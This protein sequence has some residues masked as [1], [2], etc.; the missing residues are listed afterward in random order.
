V[1][2]FAALFSSSRYAMEQFSMTST[3]IDG[4]GVQS[5]NNATILR[6]NR[7]REAAIGAG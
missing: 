5:Q 1:V 6:K 3:F 4:N 2:R 7:F